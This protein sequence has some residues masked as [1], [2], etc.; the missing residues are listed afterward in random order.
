MAGAG[1]RFS[2][3][4]FGLPKPYLPVAGRSMY[5]WPWLAIEGLEIDCEWS[6]AIQSDHKSL[7]K[8]SLPREKENITPFLIEKIT[9]GPAET[10]YLAVENKPKEAPL[11]IIDCDLYFESQS[12]KR[13]INSTRAGHLLWFE[14]NADKYSYLRLDESGNVIET[15]EKRVISRNAIA[16]CYVFPS[17]R[18]FQQSYLA[19]RAEVDR[20]VYVAPLFNH[21]V[22]S[23]ERVRGHRCDFYASF[24]T[25]D[26]LARYESLLVKK[27]PV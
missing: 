22:K 16:G 12:L 3:Q 2:S 7:F 25:P 15:A 6:F 10:A 11:I 27:R 19:E 4:G 17:V 13:L 26:E 18:A 5:H 20:E 8:S 9:R 21:L 14:S 1:Q 23:G 24:G